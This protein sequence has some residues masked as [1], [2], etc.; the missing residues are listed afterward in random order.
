MRRS[1]TLKP[2]RRFIDISQMRL[3][4]SLAIRGRPPRAGDFQRQYKRKPSRCHR[5]TVSGLTMVTAFQHRRAQPLKPY[6][7]QPIEER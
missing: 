3:R 7:D 5:T 2:A 6:E 4:S 1:F